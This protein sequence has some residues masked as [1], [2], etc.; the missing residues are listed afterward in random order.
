MATYNFTGFAP[1]A[2]SQPTGSTMQLEP[3]WD[4]QDDGYDFEITDD[5]SDFQGDANN[6][7][8]GDDTSQQ[9]AVVRDETYDQDGPNTITG[10]TNDDTLRGGGG[11][12]SIEGGEGEDSID[13]GAGDDSIYGDA[14]NDTMSGGDGTGYGDSIDA[15]A[16]TDGTEIETG[17]GDDTITG[18]QGDDRLLGEDDADTFIVEDN[19]GND[20]IDLTNLSGPVTVTYSGEEAGTITDGTYSSKFSVRDQ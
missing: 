8:T 14:G 2:F 13:G 19:F 9:T 4:G 11:N 12:D 18:G 15:S 3:D 16:T 1:D 10:T 7:E 20:T 5:E 6:N 17:G